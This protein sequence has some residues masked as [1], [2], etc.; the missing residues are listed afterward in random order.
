MSLGP[1]STLIYGTHSFHY[2]HSGFNPAT[3][4]HFSDTSDVTIDIVYIDSVTVKL[5]DDTFR[6]DSMSSSGVL[7][8]HYLSPT[9]AN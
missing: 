2:I 1:I 9:N 5:K 6:Y 8:F 7:Y 4:T 3:N